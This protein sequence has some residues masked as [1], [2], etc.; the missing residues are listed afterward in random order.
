MSRP[1]YIAA[2]WKMHGSKET[3]KTLLTKLKQALVDYQK[4]QILIAAPFVYLD[5]LSEL[6]VD[7]RLKFGAQNV[8]QFEQGAY[9]G[10]VS[11]AMLADIGCSFALL[12]HSERRHLFA[13]NNQ[14]IAEKCKQLLKQDLQAIFCVGETLQQRE[15]GQTESVVKQQVQA[16]IDAVGIKALG[17]SILAYEPVWAIGSGKTASPEQAQEVH[18]MLR[19]YL[20]EQDQTLAENIAIIYGGSVNEKNAQSLFEQKDI[21]GGLIGGA[22]LQAES[23][24]NICKVV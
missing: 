17:K 16:L 5:Q 12:G 23:F 4:A 9:T 20:A 1:F 11:A 15:A 18:A 22:S 3:N 14:L 6:L 10:E 19:A 8:S 2:N 24:L 13:E 7:S 21:D